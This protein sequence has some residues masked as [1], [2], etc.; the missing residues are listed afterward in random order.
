MRTVFTAFGICALLATPISAF[1]AAYTWTG[2]TN[3]DWSTANNWPNVA[4]FPDDPTDTATINANPNGKQ[5]VFNNPTPITVNTIDINANTNAVTVS[6][7]VAG[8]V[9]ITNNCVWIV[10]H[11]SGAATATLHVSG[12]TFA[13]RK[14]YFSGSSSSAI[15]NFDVGVTVQDAGG[16]NVWD[17][18]VRG[19]VDWTIGNG[20]A[21]NVKD[22]ELDGFNGANWT[23]TGRLSTIFVTSFKSNRQPMQF[24]GSVRI[25]HV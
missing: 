24:N 15:G 19:N 1:A 23:A 4:G 20:V 2:A 14:M 21:I 22:L 25:V 9:L 6:L 13:P 5:P 17:T 10:C 12:G 16:D 3:Q 7:K 18:W 11:W 8:G